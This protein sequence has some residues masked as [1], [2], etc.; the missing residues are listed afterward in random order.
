M[1]I[2]AQLSVIIDRATEIFGSRAAALDWIDKRSAT[3]GGSPRELA[4]TVDGQQKVL[5]HLA[6]ISRHRFG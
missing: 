6:G 3:L 2:D 1:N 4:E 5:L